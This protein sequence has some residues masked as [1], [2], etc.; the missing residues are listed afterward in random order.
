MRKESFFGLLFIA[1][2]LTTGCM[3]MA[4]K[5]NNIQTVKLI[6][7]SIDMNNG[8][9]HSLSIQA[10]APKELAKQITPIAEKRDLVLV[11]TECQADAC[12]MIFKRKEESKDKTVGSGYTSS[13]RDGSGGGGHSSVTT[14]NMSF[15]SKIFVDIKKD[16]AGATI[17][18][19]GVPVI[20]G[21]LSCP[22]VLEQRQVCVAQ[23][24]HVQGEQTPAQSFQAQWGV[25]ISGALEA[26]IISGIIAELQMIEPEETSAGTDST[27]VNTESSTDEDSDGTEG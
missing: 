7:S 21:Q 16:A 19:I 27:D 20:K 8:I 6:H 17:E 10:I 14:Y 13:T 24:F 23:D 2:L 15:S 26:E 18:M 1:A 12:D 11:K 3:K 4:M 25:D 9:P 22:H 5:M